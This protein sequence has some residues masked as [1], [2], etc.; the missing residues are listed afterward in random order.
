MARRARPQLSRPPFRTACTY[1][2]GLILN[3]SPP[4]WQVQPGYCSILNTPPAPTPHRTPVC[5][6]LASSSS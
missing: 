2:H 1:L 3:L 4:L 6:L 5:P